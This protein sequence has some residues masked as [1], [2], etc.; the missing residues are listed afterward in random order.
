[1]DISQLTSDSIRRNNFIKGH[2]LE[3]TK[4]PLANYTPT[5]IENLPSNYVDGKNYSIK[6]TGNLT[7]HQVTKPVT[8]D[9]S[10]KLTG[11]TLTGSAT[12][13]VKLS[14]FGVGPIS[15]LGVLQTQ[16]D[17]K[18]DLNFIAKPTG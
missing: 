15:L 10:V 6:V 16:D 4:Y 7:V 13:T 9:V 18:L 5:K 12:A 1:M 14:D 8:F 3:S 2:F 17:A 11:D